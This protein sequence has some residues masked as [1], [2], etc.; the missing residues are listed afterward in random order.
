MKT[1]LL[2]RLHSAPEI[3]E[4]RIAPA[5]IFTFVDTDGDNVTV[6]STKGTNAQLAAVMQ[7]V[8]S[9]TGFQLQTIALASQPGIFQG[10]TLVVS[11]A[12]AGGGNGFVDVGSINATG[13]DLSSVTIDG[14][15]GYINAG[16]ANIKTAGL[17]SLSAVS[18]GERGIAT[19]GAGAS[20]IS[21]IFG[22]VGSFVLSGNLNGATFQV[23]GSAVDPDP[24][25]HS[26]TD[27][28]AT[29]GAV[30][31]GGSVLG[32]AAAGSGQIYAKGRIGTIQ[33]GTQGV[34]GGNISG[35]TGAESGRIWTEGGF[36]SATI[37]GSIIGGNSVGA[38]DSGQLFGGGQSN[39]VLVKG[40][41][42]GGLG[43][44]SG[45]VLNNRGLGTVTIQ[46]G[47]EGGDGTGSGTLASNGKI[48]SVTVVGGG[49]TGGDG[50]ESGV[51][52]STGTIQTL[53]ITGNVQGGNGA[54][55][56]IIGSAATIQN[57][58]VDG[59]VIGG[60]GFQ[61]GALGSL[62]GL[63]TVRV[64]GDL[65]GGPAIKSGQIVSAA[66]IQSVT[67]DGS[68]IGGAGFESGAIGSLVGLGPVKIGGDLVAGT[69][70]FSGVIVSG[71]GDFVGAA[72]GSI[73]SV[74]IGGSIDGDLGPNFTAGANSASILTDGALG[75]VIVRDDVIG[76]DSTEVGTIVGRT[77]ASVL[78]EGSLTGGDGE[79]SGTILATVKLGPVTVLD[80]V[81]GGAGES[82]G[83]IRSAGSMGAVTIGGTLSGGTGDFSGMVETQGEPA[84]SKMGAVKITG[85]I[86]G[87]AGRNSGSVHSSG[88]L[89]SLT[90]DELRGY[91]GTAGR[92]I[93]FGSGS[94]SSE[95]D[96]GPVKIVGSILGGTGDESGKI[97]SGANL[98][99]LT[100]GN[101][102]SGGSGDYDTTADTLAQLGQVYVEGALGP[103]KIGANLSGGSGAH[104]GEIRA[105]SIKSVSIATFLE[106]ST[107]D[108][109][110]GL[111]STE[112][113]IGDVTVGTE[114]L[115][116]SAERSGFIASAAR[117][118]SLRA[119][120]IDSETG[121]RVLISALDEI[122]S[123][124]L[125]GSIAFADII[126]GMDIEGDVVKAG[127]K[128]GTVN[129]GGDFLAT[130]IVAS[131]LPGDDGDYGTGDDQSLSDIEESD[132]ISRIASVIIGGEVLDDVRQIVGE[133]FGIV[134]D[135]VVQVKVGVQNIPL[136]SGPRNDY[137]SIGE[138][139]VA[140]NELEVD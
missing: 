24:L 86:V 139:T 128:I 89:T 64:T 137:L 104:S 118:L 132:L 74:T 75:A 2:H 68:V 103:V 131:A 50:N 28:A 120:S 32:G 33:V 78:I 138:T 59:S 72:T 79:S 43:E 126:A 129:I 84:D 54:Q 55:S 88:A 100:V 107:G 112:G 63:G 93:G 5:A 25:V 20:L 23:L 38:T 7:L 83:A 90:A 3:L 108:N 110:G 37:E 66:K 101:K 70:A 17:K 117:L 58:T 127:S 130:N 98:T 1:A 135:H 82:S 73:A 119:G 14:D 44:D 47:I 85:A 67:V 15:L 91:T 11:A 22:G 21:T 34:T 105:G 18:L 13:L 102:L 30:K 124:I 48:T 136:H 41:L 109:S 97:T 39:K 133:N 65:Q 115:A 12:P 16:D 8:G 6:S 134:A 46:Q 4:A 36:G 81:T 42:I 114:I 140:I 31:I 121:E 57:L 69:G 35:G 94:V 106:G 52:R 29:I 92:S 80:D 60:G 95:L 62:L 56:G 87:G 96:M 123:I 53:K 125:T 71:S 27:A 10:T 26:N 9:G 111:T 77:I 51:I 76:G 99:S 61:S 122:K 40:K 45:Q 19:Q 49:V 113:D 116:G